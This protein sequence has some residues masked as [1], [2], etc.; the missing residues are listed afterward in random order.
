MSLNYKHL[1][2]FWAVAHGGN[3]TRAASQL[4]VSQSA[5]SVQIKKLEE[6]IGHDL[7]ERRGNGLVL[8][9][10]GGIALDYADTIFGA[11]EELV[12]TLRGHD[13]A[14]RQTLRVGAISTLSRNFQWKFLAPL[15]DRDDVLIVVRSGSQERLLADLESH[16]IDVVLTNVPPMRDVSTL[17]GIHDFRAARQPHWQRPECE[18]RGRPG[19]AAAGKFADRANHRNQHSDRL[20]CAVRAAGRAPGVSRRGGRH[21]A[22]S[23]DGAL[24]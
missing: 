18:Q 9:E 8:S 7:F 5:L 19:H 16:A 11:G 17:G 13:T 3:L 22:D 24:G 15:F 2:Y 23:S 14:A 12:N 21:G 1:R 10:T 6:W 20:R 4:H